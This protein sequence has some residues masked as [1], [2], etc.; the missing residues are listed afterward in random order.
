[1]GNNG[2]GIY[3]RDRDACGGGVAV[4]TENQMPAKVRYDLMPADTE[5]LSLPI[6]LPH[7]KLW[8]QDV[9]ADLQMQRF[10]YLDKL[11]ELLDQVR[12][13]YV[14]CALKEKLQAITNACKF[15]QMLDKPT[16][17]CIWKNG[18]KS[19]ACINHVFTNLS[20]L[21]SNGISITVGGND[22][23]FYGACKKDRGSGD[24]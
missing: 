14:H 23:L 18:F 13:E 5:V 15:V 10:I 24:Q 17:V 19:S 7:L 3:R 6:H 21:Y 9:S 1:M 4:Y 16:G 2:Y 12:Q 8:W 20:H 11:H 22:H